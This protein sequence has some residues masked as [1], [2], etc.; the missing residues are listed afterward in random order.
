MK[1]KET[2]EYPF[3][4]AFHDKSY[5]ISH[6][7]KKAVVLREPRESREYRMENKGQKEL[8]VYKIDGGLISSNVVLKCDN[9]ICLRDHGLKWRASMLELFCQK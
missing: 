6:D 3:F 1:I 5:I 9:G 8:V 2:E 4:N 7:D